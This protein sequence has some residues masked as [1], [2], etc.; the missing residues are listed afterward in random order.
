[1]RSWPVIAAAVVPVIASFGVL[2]SA[3]PLAM[4]A[5]TNAPKAAPTPVT[6]ETVA[7]G[8]SHPWS[9]QFLPDGRILVTERD[10][11]LRLVAKDGKLSA[12]IECVPEVRARSQQQAAGAKPRPKGAGRQK[13]TGRHKDAKVA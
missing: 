2:S 9:L 8:L 11:R 3:V 5:K 10:G 13:V 4:A 12:P 7:K 1:M 6:V